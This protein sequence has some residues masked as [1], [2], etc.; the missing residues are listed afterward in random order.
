MSDLWLGSSSIPAFDDVEPDKAQALR[1][2][3]EAAEAYGAWQLWWMK[4]CEEH[5]QLVVD[6][7]CDMFQEGA[8]LLTAMGVDSIESA[9]IRMR[10]RNEA[11]GREY[12]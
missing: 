2:L 9:M 4:P 11:R 10:E 3:E 7:V 6:E 8:N 1:L 5:R 12:S